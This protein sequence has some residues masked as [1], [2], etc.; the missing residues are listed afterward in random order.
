MFVGSALTLLHNGDITLNCG[1][2]QDPLNA[3]VRSFTYCGVDGTDDGDRFF[4]DL[5]LAGHAHACL[6]QMQLLPGGLADRNVDE[7]VRI[8]DKT[9]IDLVF[10]GF[11]SGH[12]ALLAVEKRWLALWRVLTAEHSKRS[13]KN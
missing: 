1:S 6:E 11:S 10:L 5:G 8:L 9:W 3:R 7:A 13:Q 4:D 2:W 12:V